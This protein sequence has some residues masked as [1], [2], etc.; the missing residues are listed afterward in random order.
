MS[1]VFQGIH[2]VTEIMLEVYFLRRSHIIDISTH[3]VKKN[4]KDI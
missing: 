1:S 3:F 4:K 2:D